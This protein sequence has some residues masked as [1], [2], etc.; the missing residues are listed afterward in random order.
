MPFIHIILMKTIQ[1]REFMIDKRIGKR[2][3]ECRER[4]GLTQEQFAEKTGLTPNYISTLE[5]GASFPRCDKL[6]LIMNALETN[7]DAIFCDVLEHSADYQASVLSRRL[8]AL[9]PREQKRIL[10]ILELMIR[11]AEENN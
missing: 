8:E 2:I 9:P 7:A 6:I 5:R 11:Q 4:L 1:R 10:D 3:K